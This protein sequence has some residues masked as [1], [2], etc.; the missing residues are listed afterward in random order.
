VLLAL[1]EVFNQWYIQVEGKYVKLV[2]TN[3]ADLITPI[4]L[5]YWLTGDG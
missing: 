3:I 1:F 5:A 4:A 2:P